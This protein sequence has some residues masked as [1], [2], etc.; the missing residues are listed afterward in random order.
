M[1]IIRKG[2][3]IANK[4]LHEI[5]SEAPKKVQI[6]TKAPANPKQLLDRLKGVRNQ[7][8]TSNTLRFT[9]DGNI[10][11]LTRQLAKTDLVNL[12]IQD[13]DLEEIFMQYYEGKHA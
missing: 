6:V 1:A 2:K 13:T 7:T 3:L 5:V 8:Q 4:P 11:A 9:F 12:T 10:N